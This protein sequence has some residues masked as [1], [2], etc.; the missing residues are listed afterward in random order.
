MSILS[1]VVG[2]IS[3]GAENRRTAAHFAVISPTMERPGERKIVLR[4]FENGLT[5]FHLRRPHWSAT[6]FKNWLS[7]FPA[8]LRSRVF[9]HQYP[10]LV[11]KFGLAGFHLAHGTAF[12]SIS[13]CGMLSAQCE[14][15]QSVLR[16]G[17]KCARIMLG[18]VFPPEKYDVTVPRRTPEEYA[19]IVAY[20]RAHGGK[21]EVLAFGGV[22]AGNIRFCREAGFDG[23][24]VVGAVWDAADPVK[25]F[26]NLIREW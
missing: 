23:V 17:E 6:Q 25:A 18:P 13:A 21:A 2:L 7:A 4:L 24:G 3:R 11:R 26:K 5:A 16:C 14:D 10:Q 9:V 1:K 15:F 22:N 19:A 12:P 8:E 20:W